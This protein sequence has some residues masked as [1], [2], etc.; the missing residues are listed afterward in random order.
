[1]KPKTVN[2]LYWTFT[3]IFSALMLFSS[4]GSIIGDPQTKAYIHDFLGYPLY[5]IPFTGYAKV[6]GVIGILVPGFKVLK[7][8]SY[9]GLFFDIAALVYSSI[10]LANG[11]NADMAMLLIWIVPG[12]LSYVFWKKKMKLTHVP[13]SNPGGG[14][15]GGGK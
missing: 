3:I 6:L 12:I 9:A 13:F 2:I 10:A 8:W 5:F 1:M 4:Y 15:G 14:T 7:E 11:L